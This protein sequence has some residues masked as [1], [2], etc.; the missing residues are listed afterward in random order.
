MIALIA[1]VGN[2]NVIGYKGQ[3]PWGRLQNDLK[4]FQALTMGRPVVVGARTM[5]SIG[6]ALPGRRMIVLTHEPKKFESLGG[7]VTIQDLNFIYDLAKRDCVFIA[8][9][10]GVYRQFIDKAD[11]AYITRIHADFEGDTFFPE[12]PASEWGNVNSLSARDGQYDTSFELW[13]RGYSRKL[14]AVEEELLRF[15][16]VCN[17]SFELVSPLG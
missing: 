15:N 17:R 10:E 6:K 16:R 1:A 8:G 7:C 11:V 9:G 13:V 14:P 3:M 2:G 12:F 5:E 4:Q